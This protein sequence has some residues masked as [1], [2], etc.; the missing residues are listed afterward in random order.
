MRALADRLVA[1]T[2]NTVELIPTLGTL[3][4]LADRSGHQEH[5]LTTW[6]FETAGSWTQTPEPSTPHDQPGTAGGEAGERRDRTAAQNG[7][8][9]E[10]LNG[11]PILNS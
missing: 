8:K 11:W 3:L 2:P 9:N 5:R 10:I 4:A 7:S 1:L 6:K